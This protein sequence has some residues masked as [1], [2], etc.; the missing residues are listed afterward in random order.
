MNKNTK[1]IRREVRV[2]RKNGND[3]LSINVPAPGYHNQMKPTFRLITVPT[4]RMDKTGVVSQNNRRNM[5]E[6]VYHNTD[7]VGK[8]F[9][10]T[11]HEP[12]NSERAVVFANHAYIAKDERERNQYRQF[13]QA[14]V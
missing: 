14:R 1:R 3:A 12:I 10:V 9:S 13:S 11:S 6:H 2:E 5:R 8:T 4:A 7:N